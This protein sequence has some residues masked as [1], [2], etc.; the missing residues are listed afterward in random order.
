MQDLDSLFALSDSMVDRAHRPIAMTV[1]V[2]EGL[3]RC[4]RAFRRSLMASRY[5]GCSAGAGLAS[6]VCSTGIANVHSSVTK[7]IQIVSGP[8]IFPR[9]ISSLWNF[10]CAMDVDRKAII[11]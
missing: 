6:A 1:S 8:F 11:S 7:V 3:L 4:F 5:S 2:I 10:V 9:G